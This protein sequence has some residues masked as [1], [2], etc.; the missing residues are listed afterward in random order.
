VGKRVLVTGASGFVGGHL[1]PL[2]DAP[3]TQIEAWTRDPVSGDPR[4][5]WTVIDMAD[6]AHVR[7]AIDAAPPDEVYHLAGAAHVGLSFGSVTSTLE[8]NVL[9]TAHLIDALRRAAPTARVLMTCSSTVYRTS[10]QALREDAPLGPASP[11]A[12]SKLAQERLALRAFA[13]DGQPTIVVR[14]FN[15]VGPGQTPTFFAPSFARQIAEIEAGLREPVLR[16]GNLGTRRDLTDVRDVVRAYQALMARGA[17]GSVYNVCSGTAHAIGDV[18]HMLL[19]RCDRKVDVVVDSA[20][21][22]PNDN[23]LVLGSYSRLHDATGWR[24]LVPIEQT[25]ADLLADWRRRVGR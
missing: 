18:L 16:V 19:A 2:V 7:A 6:G 1:L 14:A 22:R 15:H 25:L 11:Y 5:R 21:L 8:A 9:G 23:P 24:P 4:A 12:L 13:E 20:L 17:A 3:G 10:A